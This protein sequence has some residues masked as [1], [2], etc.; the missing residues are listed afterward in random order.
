MKFF[1][2]SIAVLVRQTNIVW[3]AFIAF[4]ST[5]HVL[6]LH[7]L[8]Y[9]GRLS[10]SVLRSSKYLQVSIWTEPHACVFVC[11]HARICLNACLC[12]NKHVLVCAVAKLIYFYSY[13]H[14]LMVSFII[15]NL[16]TCAVWLLYLGEMWFKPGRAI[17]GIISLV[18]HL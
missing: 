10:S 16:R 4:L 14:Y 2:A 1:A 7:V 11:A 15:D 17:D 9:N 18:T 6:K 3:V 12:V 8:Q 5:S 13:W